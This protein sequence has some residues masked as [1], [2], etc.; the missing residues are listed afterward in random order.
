MTHR[1]LAGN[2]R[3]I[4]LFGGAV[5]GNADSDHSIQAI[6]ERDLLLF[7]DCV[8]VWESAGIS[9][10]DLLVGES[11]AL[12]EV[13]HAACPPQTPERRRGCAAGIASAATNSASASSAAAAAAVAQPPSRR[14]RLLA[15]T[16]RLQRFDAWETKWCP[17]ILRK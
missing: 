8:A 12:L 3:N 1:V 2:P 11:S 17:A 15:M 9:Y 6:L 10:G 13:A 5:V 7:K 4:D 14:R 16:S